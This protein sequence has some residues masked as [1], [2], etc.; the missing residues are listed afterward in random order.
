MAVSLLCPV[1]LWDSGVPGQGPTP[2][3]HTLGCHES[4]S[5]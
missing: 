1:F 5:P 4:P 2:Q 3:L